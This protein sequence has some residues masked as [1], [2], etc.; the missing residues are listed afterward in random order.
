[1]ELNRCGHYKL[2]GEKK[3]VS[4]GKITDNGFG[5]TWG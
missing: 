2:Y 5:T 1:M 4:H 3:A